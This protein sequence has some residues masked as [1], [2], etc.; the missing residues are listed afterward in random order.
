M[1]KINFK[2]KILLYFLTVAI[3]P[4]AISMALSYYS[5]NKRLQQDYR[6]LNYI[7][8]QNEMNKVNL[9]FN[10]Q[11]DILKTIA[12]A[13]SYIDQSSSSIQSFLS[14]QI[15]IGRHFL[16][17]YI[18]M[19]DGTVYHSDK[20]IELPKI[21]FTKLYGYVYA[22][23]NQGILWM[24]PYTDAISNTKCIGISKSIY[25]SHG[26]EC[27][28]LV[29][30]IPLKSFDE[31]IDKAKY[32]NGMEMYFI[33]SS[34]FI[35]YDPS[36]KY[37]ESVNISDSN[38]ILKPFSNEIMKWNEGH[39]E[40]DN[41]G[42]D[43][44]CTYSTIN[45]N[46]W[47][48][49]SLVEKNI[50][51]ESLNQINKRMYSLTIAHGILCILLAVGFSMIMSTSIAKPLI[52]LR[53]GAKAISEGNLDSRIEINSND[54][55]REVADAFNDMA[56]N[57]K[58]TYTDLLKRTNELYL[59]NEE[60]H[61]INIEL[62]ASYEQLEATAGQLNES[63]MQLRKKY[64]E[65]QTLNKISNTL[66]S[67][68]DLNNMLSTVVN[69]VTDITEGL[70][71]AIRLISDKDPYKLELKALKGVRTEKYDRGSI[72]IRENIVGQAVEKKQSIVIELQDE[73]IPLKYY[74]VLYKENEARC[75]VITPIMVKSKV[76]GIMC[77]TLKQE[78]KDELIELIS[79]LSNNIAI[80]IDNA[81]AYENLKQSYLKAVQSLVSVVEAKDEYTESHSVRVAKYSAFIASEMNYP[82]SFIEDIWVAGVLHDIGKIGI[83]DSILNKDGALTEDEYN[84]IKQHPGIAYKIVSKI[85]LGDDILKA[86]KHHH[87]RFD[88]KGY[89]DMIK[90]DSIP[91]MA[92]IISVADAFDAITSNRPYRKS[93]S[94]MQGI[95]EIVTNRGTQFNPMVVQILEKMF[96]LKQE[97]FEKIYNDEEIEFF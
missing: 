48:I 92:S 40:F 23:K 97:V 33:N 13:Y 11:E 24:E 59:N 87:E 75:I 84:T 63:D 22:R 67:T 70:T 72:D 29:G 81:R 64:N 90:G 88:G 41:H 69:Q 89:P 51:F 17:I 12:E 28:V 54:E 37:S 77:T 79:S 31:M 50:F 36:G 66:A 32:M 1:H 34:G 4:F 94:I 56:G 9:V 47:K 85:G 25:D 73:N 21:D 61:S 78:A 26:K 38:F 7:Y 39:Q 95:N 58:N 55:I 16:S 71:C 15:E 46:G 5:F 53:N 96:L 44:I 2:L 76:I 86:I 93:R 30:N 35:K 14:R 91:I 83:D 60:L 80:A 43:W 6:K 68:M 52:K 42:K 18:I 27:G 45:S 62:A 19:N 82:K 74:E 49:V 57:L 20:N 10:E 65:L 3:I 8:V